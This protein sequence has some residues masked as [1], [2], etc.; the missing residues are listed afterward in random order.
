MGRNGTRFPPPLPHRRHCH[1]HPRTL[2]HLKTDALLAPQH[3]LPVLP[4]LMFLHERRD[5]DSYVVL[6]DWQL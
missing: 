1:R 2:P 4:L 3:R 6:N 5:T